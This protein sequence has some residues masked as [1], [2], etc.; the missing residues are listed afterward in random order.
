MKK[1]PA[2]RTVVNLRRAYFECRYGQLHVRTA[3]PSTGGFDE[4]VPLLLLHDCPYSSL[5]CVPLLTAIGADRSAYAADTP[6]FG[7]SDAPPKRPTIADYA[8]AIG[9]FLDNL[10]LRRL[11][12]LGHHAGAAIAAELAIARPTAVRRLVFVGLPVHTTQERD[13]F[14]A[15]PYPKPPSADGGHAREEWTRALAQGGAGATP[16]ELGSS[17]AQS[18]ASGPHGWW[19]PAAAFQWPAHERLPLVTQP[20]LVLRPKDALWEATLRGQRLLRSADWQDLPAAGSS[21]L[22]AGASDVAV[23]VRRFLDR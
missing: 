8:A 3:F 21:V 7:E 5:T 20:A 23:R 11:D 17:L 14:I 16:A 4:N 18:L 19:G 2:S 9:D 22:E 1:P 13:G 15:H 6:G 12:V 10:R